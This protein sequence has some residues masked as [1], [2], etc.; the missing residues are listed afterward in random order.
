LN[1]SASE[2]EF[3][4]ALELNPNSGDAHQNYAMSL[5]A[6]GRFD[7]AM[8]HLK[9]AQEIDPLSPITKAEIGNLFYFSRQYDLAIEQFQKIIEMDPNFAPAHNRLQR[10]YLAKG[11]YEEAI[12]EQKKAIASDPPEG[13]WGRTADLG[14]AYAVAGKR[15]EAQKILDELK[16]LAKQRYVPPNAFAVIYM[17]LGDKDQAF[18]WL[19]KTF[20]ARPDNLYFLKVSPQYD[21]LRSDPRFAE[22][23]RRLKLAP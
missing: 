4:L 7:E 14:Y 20:E 8:L 3:K 11:M 17:G 19:D 18:A 22:L 5:A 23:L 12:T 1:W 21:S 16:E 15:D 10:A 2:E 6:W 13:S 9:R